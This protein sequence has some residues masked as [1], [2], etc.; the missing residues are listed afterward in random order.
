MSFVI[1]LGGGGRLFPI[2]TIK[3]CLPIVSFVVAVG[4]FKSLNRRAVCLLVLRENFA[5]RRMV[6]LLK[7]LLLLYCVVCRFCLFLIWNRQHCHY[8][9]F[10]PVSYC[11]T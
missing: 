4:I 8:C 5:T 10:T 3:A 6:A 11:T 9:N 2:T 1:F 7:S